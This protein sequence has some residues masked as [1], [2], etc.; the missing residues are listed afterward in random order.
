[1]SEKTVRI[2]C[3]NCGDLTRGLASKG[4][5]VVCKAPLIEM[6]P[7]SGEYLEL[8]I[9]DQLAR[10]QVDGLPSDYS[11]ALDLEAWATVNEPVPPSLIPVPALLEIDEPSPTLP[12]D[13]WKA[14]NDTDV[15]R[16]I[17]R[18]DV[19]FVVA[20]I[21]LIVTAAYSALE[22][23]ASFTWE[24]RDIEFWN[25][26]ERLESGYVV[27]Y[28][29]TAA[30]FI[31]WSYRAHSNLDLFGR[32]KLTHEHWA[33]LGWWFAPIAN[34]WMPYRVIFET[35]RGSVAPPSDPAWKATKLPSIVVWW[36]GLFIGGLVARIVATALSADVYS[37]E[38]VDRAITVIG[39]SFI[40]WGVAAVAA[41]RMMWT[42][43]QA[44]RHIYGMSRCMPPPLPPKEEPPVRDDG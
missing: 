5:C 24:Q 20:T 16:G 21:L 30:A 41:I 18:L 15:E 14:A 42:I 40:V 23:W 28:L 3:G 10:R 12:H 34:T 9:S 17:R 36:T 35:A 27:L 43:R 22:V 29:L 25:M 8:W 6:R 37:Y 4:L 7:A 31:A 11:I 13:Y 19:V 26:L 1:M 38:G 39:L 2:V 32:G 33:T 44:Q